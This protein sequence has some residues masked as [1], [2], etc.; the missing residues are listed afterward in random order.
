MSLMIEELS[1]LR[2]PALML[3]AARFGLNEY[4]RE[5]DLKR[6]LKAQMPPAPVE[7]LA[8]LME[9]EAGL[10]EIRRQGES[11]YSIGRHIEVLIAV[12]AEARLISRAAAAPARRA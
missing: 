6:L 1:A 5:R 11:G 9:Q 10:E 4:R 2:R 7:A 8:A 12:L 3:R